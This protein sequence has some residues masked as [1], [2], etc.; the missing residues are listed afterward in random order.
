MTMHRSERGLTLIELLVTIAIGSFVV[1]TATSLYLTAV[2]SHAIEAS[3]LEPADNAA[4]A[5]ALISRDLQQ[6]GRPPPMEFASISTLIPETS[7]ASPKCE[8]TNAWVARTDLRVFASNDPGGAPHAFDRC[9]TLDASTLSDVVMIWTTDMARDHSEPITVSYYLTPAPRETKTLPCA[10]VSS[11]YRMVQQRNKRPY[12]E[13]VVANIEAL[14]FTFGIDNNNDRGVDGYFT[15]DAV[16]HWGA[17][18]SVRVEV[19]ARASCPLSNFANT[20]IYNVGEHVL[21]PGDRFRRVALSM[22]SSLRYS[23]Q[24]LSEI[25]HAPTSNPP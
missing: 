12:R 4:L 17:V 7:P 5:L 13:E 18:I 6:A 23:A 24:Y 9:L 19:V 21:R 8:N 2:R 11:L 25:S 20:S 3:V 10:P 15:A 16:T 22:V 14:Q 1:G